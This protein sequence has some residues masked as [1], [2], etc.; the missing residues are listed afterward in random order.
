MDYLLDLAGF[1]ADK[2]DTDKKEEKDYKDYLHDT[3]FLI[4]EMQKLEILTYTPYCQ[5]GIFAN[6]KSPIGGIEPYY[7]GVYDFLKSKQIIQ[8]KPEGL[9]RFQYTINPIV[10]KFNEEQFKAF[11]EQNEKHKDLI[12]IYKCFP[13]IYGKLLAFLKNVYMTKTAPPPQQPAPPQLVQN[14]IALQNRRPVLP[15][16]GFIAG[17]QRVQGG[18]KRKKTRFITRQLR[19]RQDKAVHRTKR[20]RKREQ[21]V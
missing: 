12:N 3:N 19:H 21:S 17:P 10:L 7:L 14:Q 16:R 15:Q 13:I 2:P 18:T 9:N 6:Y 20:R 8:E 11:F 4:D 5:K 1:I